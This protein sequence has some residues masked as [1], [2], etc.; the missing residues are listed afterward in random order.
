MELIEDLEV[1]LLQIANLDEKPDKTTLQMISRGIESRG[2]L[3]QIRMSDFRRSLN[4]EK[5]K[6]I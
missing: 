4:P 1:I 6:N 3:F 5:S 2:I